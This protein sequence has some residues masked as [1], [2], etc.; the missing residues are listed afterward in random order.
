MSSTSANGN[1]L[2]VESINDNYNGQN[3][4]DHFIQPSILPTTTTSS[5]STPSKRNNFD[6][7]NK[8]NFKK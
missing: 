3:G 2:I 8:E 4:D 1:E 7:S 6:I 5:L